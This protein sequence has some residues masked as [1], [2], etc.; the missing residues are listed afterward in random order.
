MK[1]KLVKESLNE[2]F[3]EEGDPIWDM[4]I[5]ELAL[6][7]KEMPELE[8]SGKSP[9]ELM[10]LGI[11]YRRYKLVDYAIKKGANQLWWQKGG[12]YG[13]YHG[14]TINLVDS[15][16]RIIKTNGYDK[17]TYQ[18]VIHRDWRTGKFVKNKNGYLST[19]KIFSDKYDPV[20]EQ[21]LKQL[22]D[23]ITKSAGLIS[24]INKLNKE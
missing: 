7:Q 8:L 12:Y 16:E 20:D 19:S 15:L 23:L 1:A 5:G 6:L 4:G 22:K 9:N 2:K 14:L 17:I 11:H 13:G 21:F 24:I 18:S 10:I 3:S